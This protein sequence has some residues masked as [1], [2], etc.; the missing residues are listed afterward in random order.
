M[1]QYLC[2]KNNIRCNNL[3]LTSVATNSIKLTYRLRNL[4]SNEEDP[5]LQLKRK[6][7]KGTNNST[8][9]KIKSIALI[10]RIDESFHPING[11][12]DLSSRKNHDPRD[13]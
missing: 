7:E 6:K 10:P 1:H 8:K 11:N 9:T 3:I 5:E 12:R 13:D 2:C 4:I